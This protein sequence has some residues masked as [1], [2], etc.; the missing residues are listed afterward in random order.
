MDPK[1]IAAKFVAENA[2]AAA[3]LR[4]EGA[5]SERERIQAVREQSMPGHEALIE[6]LAFDGKTSG[7][8]AAVKVLAAEKARI[9]GAAAA[10]SADAPAPV[11]TAANPSEGDGYAASAAATVRAPAGFDIDQGQ[12]KIDAEARAYMAQHPGVDYLAAVKA[13]SK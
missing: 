8:E 10:R 4:A 3:I 2:D 1:D 13:V 9:A 7:P 11:P 12:A 6:A 5:A